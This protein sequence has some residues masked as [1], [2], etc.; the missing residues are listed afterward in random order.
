MKCEDGSTTR[1]GVYVDAALMRNHD[2]LNEREAEAGTDGS[3]TFTTPEPLENPFSVF[4]RDTR[5]LIRNTYTSF[6]AHAH[7]HFRLLR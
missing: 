1:T 7:P 6:G 2:L 5:P 3:R 4:R